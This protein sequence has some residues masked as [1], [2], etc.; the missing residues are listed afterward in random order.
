[1]VKRILVAGATG[2]VG[3]AVVELLAARTDDD[4]DVQALVRR[5]GS[6]PRELLDSGRVR[7]IEFG[8]ARGDYA[9]IAGGDLRCDVVICCIGTTMRTAGSKEKFVAVEHEIPVRLAAALAAGGGRSFALVSSHGAGSPMGFYLDTKARAEKDVQTHGIAS[10]VIARPSLL[11]GPRA[12]FRPG[13]RAAILMAVPVMKV[14]QAATGRRITALNNLEPIPAEQVA[15]RLIQM[16]VDQP[17]PG[18]TILEGESLTRQV[19][20]HSRPG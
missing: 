5:P 2:L 19:A 13:E 18:L 15:R 1:M 16:S 9:R 14:L 10:V 7:E 11:L 6:L 17:K 12:E 20:P 3:R 8:C 4:I